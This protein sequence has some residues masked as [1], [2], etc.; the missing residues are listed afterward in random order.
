MVEAPAWYVLARDTATGA[1]RVFSMDRI[2]GARPVM[3]RP[4]VPDFDAACREAFGVTPM[5]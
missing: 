5:E 1:A 3:E 2:C 4:F